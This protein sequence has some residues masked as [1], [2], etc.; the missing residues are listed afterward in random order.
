MKPSR[1]RV[2]AVAGALTLSLAL[3]LTACGSTGDPMPTPTVTAPTASAPAS[4][5]PEPETE[6]TP[7]EEKP[8]TLLPGGTALANKDYFDYVNRSL[9]NRRPGVGSNDIAAMLISAGFAKGDIQVTKD[10]TPTGRKTEAIEFSVRAHD[11]CLIGQWGKSIYTSYIAPALAN[12]HCLIG[13]TQP[14]D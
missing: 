9:F 8:P 10:T 1:A 7:A 3:T 12:G 14:I 11:D 13:E 6:P 2:A 4:P 5:S